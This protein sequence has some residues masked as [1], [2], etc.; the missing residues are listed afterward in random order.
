MNVQLAQQRLKLRLTKRHCLLAARAAHPKINPQT[1]VFISHNNSPTTTS[2]TGLHTGY[3]HYDG[4]CKQFKSYLYA[5][6]LI[7]VPPDC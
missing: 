2:Y 3:D 1:H 7:V 4:W 5:E 6:K